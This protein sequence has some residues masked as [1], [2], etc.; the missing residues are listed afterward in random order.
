[1]S[2]D[3]YEEHLKRISLRKID[4]VEFDKKIEIINKEIKEYEENMKEMRKISNEFLNR[5]FTI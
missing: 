2:I 4:W 5:R 1:M 3:N